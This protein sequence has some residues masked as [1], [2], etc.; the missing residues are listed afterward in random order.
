MLKLLKA[1]FIRLKNEKTVWIV[2]IVAIFLAFITSLVFYIMAKTTDNFDTGGMI[3]VSFSGVFTFSNSF[4]VTNNMGLIIPIVI[5]VFAGKDFSYLTIR[6]KLISGNSRTKVYLSSW[7]TSLVVGTIL[8]TIYA[9]SSL[10]F[11]SLFMGYGREFDF[12]EV[13]Y[14]LKTLGLGILLFMVVES[15]AVFLTFVTKS[16]SLSIII[17]I[18]ASLFLSIITSVFMFFLSGSPVLKEIYSWTMM[19]QG[20]A[21]TSMSVDTDTLIRILISSVVGITVFTSLGIV[22]F[23]KADI[24]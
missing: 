9:L 14:I 7:M 22:I 18:G 13:L 8:I 17:S 12:G 20:L 4:S 11:A 16:M 19:S 24:K 21:L 1:D 15:I 23:K 2:G 10:L 6:N 5:C 3:V